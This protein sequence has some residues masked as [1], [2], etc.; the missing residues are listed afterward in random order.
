MT[1][2]PRERRLTS[3]D[4][5]SSGNTVKVE[6]GDH[7]T[8]SIHIRGDVSEPYSLDI[9]DA[10]EGAWIEDVKTFSG[11]ADYDDTSDRGEAWVRIRNTGGNGSGSDSA[12]V[13]I[14]AS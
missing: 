8:L 13:L 7:D 5:T 10:S 11:S 3:L 6:I 12:D 4:I 14:T 9:R 1:G 2:N